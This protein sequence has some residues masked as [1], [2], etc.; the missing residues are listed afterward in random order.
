MTT[1]PPT[2]ST[3]APADNTVSSPDSSPADTGAERED[4][5]RARKKRASRDA[6]LRAAGQLIDQRGYE[7]TRMR[8]IAARAS[9]SYQTVYN[10]FPGKARILQALLLE[11]SAG[12]HERLRGVLRQHR[13]GLPAAIDEMHA[14]S[15]ESIRPAD[16]ALWRLAALELAAE[17]HGLLDPLAREYLGQLLLERRNAGELSGS[18][19]L[20]QLTDTL[21]DLWQ[22]SVLRFALDPDASPAAALRRLHAQSALVV[23]PYLTD[24]D[25]TEAGR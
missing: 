6:I 24:P 11:R 22:H 21:F 25:G 7:A 10:Y 16:R 4:S 17:A 8:D 15:I 19:N 13:G 18:V 1:A 23:S 12:V 2:G 5:L 20:G 14:I 9:L 3:A